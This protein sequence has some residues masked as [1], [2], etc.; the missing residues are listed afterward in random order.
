MAG[1]AG[2]GNES[3]YDEDGRLLCDVIRPPYGPSRRPEETA[4]I[5]TFMRLINNK[6]IYL[7]TLRA[8]K[9]RW[10]NC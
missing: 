4:G 6:L 1:A 3:R 8:N 2:A 9:V 7:F 5:Y 10:K